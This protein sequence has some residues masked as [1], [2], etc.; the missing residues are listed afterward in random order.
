MEAAVARSQT[1]E[2]EA[3]E[4]NLYL[5]CIDPGLLKPDYSTGFAGG[6]DFTVGM[7]SI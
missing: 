3:G 4:K 6:Y 1:D 7:R 5:I 2:K